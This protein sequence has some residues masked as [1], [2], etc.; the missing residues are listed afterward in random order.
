MN[1]PA[2]R[3]RSPLAGSSALTPTPPAE[4]PV[5]PQN[6]PFGDFNDGQPVTP[7]EGPLTPHQAIA[8]TGKVPLPK[9]TTAAKPKKTAKSEEVDQEK[10]EKKVRLIG[11]LYPTDNK[12]L[13]N[14][15]VHTQNNPGPHTSLTEF[16]EIAVMEKIEE[17]EK[18]YNGGKPF[19]EA[20]SGSIRPG[21]RLR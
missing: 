7:T 11:Y 16:V 4:V 17:F 12:R 13:R 2:P 5:A 6:F 21:R 3:R 10:Q 18:K 1:S 14:T 15:V 8:K 9:V 19:P 20:P